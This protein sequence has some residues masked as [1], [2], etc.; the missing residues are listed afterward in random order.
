[1]PASI[2]KYGSILIEVTL[3][4]WVLSNKPVDEA[5][6]P[7]PIPEMTPP[8]TRMNLHCSLLLVACPPCSCCCC[9]CCCF[10]SRSSCVFNVVVVV[11][12]VIRF[13]L[14]SVSIKKKERKRQAKEQ[15]FQRAQLHR[16]D[17]VAVDKCVRPVPILMMESVLLL[18]FLKVILSYKA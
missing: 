2:F 10:C 17:S 8:V 7:L 18:M 12:V 11:V 9:G 3:R 4:P 13:A 16:N 1:M 5:M 6:T 15:L 14:R